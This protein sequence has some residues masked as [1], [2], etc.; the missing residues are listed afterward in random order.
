MIKRV[1]KVAFGSTAVSLRL[2]RS[3]PF[4]PQQR[5]TNVL[6]MMLSPLL[7]WG[8]GAWSMK[9]GFPDHT[10]KLFDQAPDGAI[11]GHEPCQL[12][13]ISEGG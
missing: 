10:A 1:L 12:L 11:V 13:G 9:V 6:R 5:A 3:L 8:C 7:P 4:Y 2:S